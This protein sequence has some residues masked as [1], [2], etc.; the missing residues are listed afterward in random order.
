MAKNRS[1]SKQRHD[2]SKKVTTPSAYGSHKSMVK[3]Q[4]EDGRLVLEDQLGEYITTRDRLD[5]GLCDPRR[6]DGRRLEGKIEIE[7]LNVH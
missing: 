4:L 7:D 3:R 2:T 6:S 1:L 5:N